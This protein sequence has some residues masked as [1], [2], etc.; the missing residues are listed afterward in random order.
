M[1]S[2]RIAFVVTS[3]V[4]LVLLIAPV[5]RTGATLIELNGLNVIGILAVPVLICLG[6]LANRRL[7]SAGAAAMFGFVLLSGF[8]IGLFYLPSAFLLL[9]PDRLRDRGRHQRLAGERSQPRHRA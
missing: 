4:S 1:H 6:P 7:R 2:R 5:Y 3:V 8:S 9:W